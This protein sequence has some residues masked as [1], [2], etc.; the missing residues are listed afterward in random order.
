MNERD[1]APRVIRVATTTLPTRW[2]DFR[3]VAY[4]SE[5][6]GQEHLAL[7]LGPEVLL[8][9]HTDQPG[10]DKPGTHGPGI[11]G[12]AFDATANGSGPRPLV[13]LHSECLTG[14]VFGSGRCDCGEQLQ[15][16]LAAIAAAGEGAVVYLRGHEGRGI[17][18]AAKI[19]AYHL[20]DQGYDTVEA[21]ERL[22]L[23]VDARD[24]R[25]G[26]AILMDLGLRTVRLLTNNPAKAT[27]LSAAGI[28]V[29]ERVPL[30]TA[31]SA[32]NARYLTT[33][34]QRMGHLLADIE[35]GPFAH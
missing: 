16:A 24:Y 14:D 28:E 18:L 5:C 1:P 26:A 32:H 22:G 13:R 29:A 6:D 8:G 4:R 10:T 25:A 34:R 3:C 19:Q 30:H 12:T 27:G 35:R 11:D 17:G 31:A 7:V 20:Q 15:T 2:A 23:P 9:R 21:N 33:K